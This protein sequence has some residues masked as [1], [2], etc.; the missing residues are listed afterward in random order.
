MVLT[1]FRILKPILFQ[2]R[3]K[4]HPYFEAWHF[5]HVAFDALKHRTLSV[6][7]GIVRAAQGEWAFIQTVHGPRCESRF[8]VFPLSDFS[9]SDNPFELRIGANRFSLDGMRLDLK[10]DQGGVRGE[11]RYP[12][13]VQPRSFQSLIGTRELYGLAPFLK[14]RHG[15]E[16]MRHEIDGAVDI[17]K[18]HLSFDG[19]HGYL[20]KNWGRSLPRAWIWIQSNEFSPAFGP[21]SFSFSLARV[22]MLGSM[23]TGF[24]CL[25]NLAGESYRFASYRGGKVEL[26]EYGKASTR[27]LISDHAHKME[28]QIR[29]LNRRKAQDS[30]DASWLTLTAPSSNLARKS[31]LENLDSHLRVILKRRHGSAE[32]IV[33]D[34]STTV[35]AA[36]IAGD[37]SELMP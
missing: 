6:L 9:Y 24:M 5:N 31:F 28:I 35:A 37:V 15:I 1:F 33:A 22:Q 7:A 25:F 4:R 23:L 3:R 30:L 32:D 29:E 18:E 10:D 11:L 16:S 8:F 19:G 14:C 13:P 20:E 12:K 36:E 17:G 26:L 27:I 21:A 34:V 2:G